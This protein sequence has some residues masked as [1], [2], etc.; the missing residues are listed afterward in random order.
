MIVKYIT[1]TNY[2][3]LS[4]TEQKCRYIIVRRDGHEDCS[5]CCG[6]ICGMCGYCDCDDI[7]EVDSE[8]WPEELNDSYEINE[9]DYAYIRDKAI[10]IVSQKFQPYGIKVSVEF[11][12]HLIDMYHKKMLMEVQ[13]K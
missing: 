3:N 1:Q 4:Q 13:E 2:N 11:L 5:I 7:Y 12:Q 8:S 10:F 9:N 6:C